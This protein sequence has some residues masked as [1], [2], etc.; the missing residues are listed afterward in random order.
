LLRRVVLREILHPFSSFSSILNL[1]AISSSETCALS[2]L[3]GVRTQKTAPFVFSCVWNY[4]F[5][6][7]GFSWAI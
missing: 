7:S 2:E 1:K 4:V 6:I 3:H 5:N